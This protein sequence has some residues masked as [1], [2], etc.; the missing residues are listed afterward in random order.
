MQTLISTFQSALVTDGLFP[1]T[2]DITPQKLA[3]LQWQSPNSFSNSATLA[4][5]LTNFTTYT[6]MF[7]MPMEFYASPEPTFYDTNS[8]FTLSTIPLDTLLSLFNATNDTSNTQSL[9]LQQNMYD[10]TVSA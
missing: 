1:S 9:F 7:D 10:L 4:S 2:A 8:N 6:S 3:V 5:S